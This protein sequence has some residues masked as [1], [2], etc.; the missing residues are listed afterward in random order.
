MTDVDFKLTLFKIRWSFNNDNPLENCRCVMAG[1]TYSLII[2]EF[3]ERNSGRYSVTAENQ[4]G[5]ATCSAEVQLEGVDFTHVIGTSLGLIP[6]DNGA[7]YTEEIITKT[8]TGHDIITETTTNK[9][10][11][12]ETK[13]VETMPLITRDL[14]IQSILPIMRDSSSQSQTATK[15]TGIQIQTEQRDKGS[16][17]EVIRTKDESSQWLSPELVTITPIIDETHISSSNLIDE[18]NVT[19]SYSYTQKSVS[20]TNDGE[21]VETTTTTTNVPVDVQHHTDYSTT[22]IKD[23]NPH[24]QPVELIINRNEPQHVPLSSMATSSSTYIREIDGYQHRSMNRFEPVN[25]IVQ[26]PIVIRSGSLPPVVSRMNFK[27]R[28]EYDYVDSE[29]EYYYYD[30]MPGA[31][32]VTESRI[33]YYKPPSRP[34]F[35]PVEL[36]IDASSIETNKRLRDTS[37]P[38]FVTKRIRSPPKYQNLMTSSFVYDYNDYD[39]SSDFVSERYAVPSGF[40]SSSTLIDRKV[41]ETKL[42]TMEMTID[43]K[44]PPTIEVPLRNATAVEGSPVRLECVVGGKY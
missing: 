28:A 16:Q 31:D 17:I 7:I 3:E 44:S 36:V 15:E 21:V 14:S 20:Y 2:D 33:N 32:Y 10:V 38:T 41:I 19:H 12:T 34:A 24:F 37:L 30:R 43:L 5:K 25:L 13:S 11:S 6:I 27:T 29:N 40:K 22:L 8:S 4:H 26:K 9:I 1:D 35:K 23:I 39:S 42:P 18:S